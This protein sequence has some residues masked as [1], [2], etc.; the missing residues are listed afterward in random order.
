MAEGSPD[1]TEPVAP[2]ETPTRSDDRYELLAD[3]TL[4]LLISRLKDKTATAA[5]IA[6]AR[7][8]VKQS[9]IKIMVSKGTKGAKLVDSL[10]V[11]E[12]GEATLPN[13]VVLR[14]G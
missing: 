14:T 3:L 6:Q 8:L 10:P 11:F 13:G 12:D 1:V 7:E 4:D 9:G 5:E 2:A